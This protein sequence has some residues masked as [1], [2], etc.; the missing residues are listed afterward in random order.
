AAGA[1]AMLRDLATVAPWP[2]SHPPSVR[3][4][5]AALGARDRP[6]EAAPRG[7][8]TGVLPVARSAFAAAPHAEMERLAAIVGSLAGVSAVAASYSEQGTPSLREALLALRAGAPD[9][10][11]VVPLHVPVEPS[12][13]SRLGRSLKRWQAETGG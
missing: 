6:E 3:K 13:R 7:T 2:R 8:G 1:R 11:L 12:F 4:P 5:G 9:A 10:I